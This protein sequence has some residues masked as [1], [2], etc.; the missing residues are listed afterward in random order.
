MIMKTGDGNPK[1]SFA[2]LFLLLCLAASSFFIPQCQAAYTLTVEVRNEFNDGPISD[3]TVMLTGPVT[4][5]GVTD[6]NGRAVFGDLPFGRYDLVVSVQDFPNSASH[7]ITVNAD[8][9]TY[10]LFGFTKAYFTYSPVQPVVDEEVVFDGTLSTSSADIIEFKWDFGDGKTASGAISSHAYAEAGSYTVL[11]TVTSAVGTSTYAQQIAV[12]K[13]ALNL[14]FWPW[15]LLLIPLIL[16]P[17]IWLLFMR[18]RYCV[19]IKTRVPINQ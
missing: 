1:R 7:K 3:A 17:L 18:R 16:I 19:V 15:I 8:T 2:V 10:V 13:P 9:T 14:P 5:S 11:L 4:M 6:S 12:A